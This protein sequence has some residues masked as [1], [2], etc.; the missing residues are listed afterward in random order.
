MKKISDSGFVLVETIVVAVIVLA[1]FVMI[2]QNLIPAIG[3]SETRLR[4]DDIDTVF[5]ANTF[6]NLLASDNNFENII[7]NAKTNG[8][9]DITDC[10]IYASAENKNMCTTLK[11]EIGVKEENGIYV[12][13]TTFDKILTIPNLPR[14]LNDYINYLDKSNELKDRGGYTLI[15]S[16]TV[17]FTSRHDENTTKD[18]NYYANIVI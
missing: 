3:E 10:N 17:T 12:I 18:I 15:M 14:G 1:I 2:Y 13:S 6:K 5:A 8:Y 4:Y 16:R 9:I 7:N 11:Q